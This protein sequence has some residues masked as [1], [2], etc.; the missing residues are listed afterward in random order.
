MLNEQQYLLLCLMEEAA[1]ISQAASKCLR[2]GPDDVYN[3]CT[4][5]ENLIYEL[6]DMYAVI[7]ELKDLGVT[8]DERVALKEDK[9]RRLARYRDISKARG[10]HE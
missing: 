7:D 6:N 3:G 4:N 5:L 8:L 10:Y 9:H 1:E 2:F